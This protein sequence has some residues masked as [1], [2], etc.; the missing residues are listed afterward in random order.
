[1]AS[2]TSLGA[3]LDR[4]ARISIGIS[5]YAH[6]EV[7]PFK[8]NLVKGHLVR[9]KLL[10]SHDNYTNAPW[11]KKLSVNTVFHQSYSK[12]W[13]DS[14]VR[15]WRR[16]PRHFSYEKSWDISIILK[17]ITSPSSIRT[18]SL[19][20]LDGLRECPHLVPYLRWLKLLNGTCTSR[21][22]GIF[23][24]HRLILGTSQSWP[25]HSRY[26]SL[27][28][29]SCWS[30]IPYTW[31]LV[32]WALHLS[33]LCDHLTKRTNS[34]LSVEERKVGSTCRGTRAAGV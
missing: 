7:W 11:E 24:W 21:S 10:F 14:S 33:D 26:A 15:S 13:L 30:R 3:W 5:L 17:K 20:S 29:H 4:T 23:L 1:M 2:G 8:H 25:D 22:A 12:C 18:T 32:S 19:P 16:S 6:R 28:G 9:C 34:K 31:K 27:S